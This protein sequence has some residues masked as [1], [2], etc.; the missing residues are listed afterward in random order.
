MKKL[1]KLFRLYSE[2]SLVCCEK[3]LVY[4]I[5]GYF[6]G[7]VCRSLSVSCLKEVELAFFNGELHILHIFVMLFQFIGYIHKLNINVGHIFFKSR[8]RLRRSYAGNNVLALCV[9]EIFS[10]YHLFACSG[11]SC[12]CN[13]RT[14]SIA[15]V[16]EYHH[17]YVNGSSP[18]VRNIVHSSVCK[19]SGVIP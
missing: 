5:N 9:Y 16:S 11:V 15:H 2:K 1:V 18:A 7:G 17:L 12:K 14:G 3:S 13:S 4:H 8:Y 19:S 6:K 10:E